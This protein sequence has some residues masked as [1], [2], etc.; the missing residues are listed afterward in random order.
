MSINFFQAK[1]NVSEKLMPDQC[2]PPK[3]NELYL[4]IFGGLKCASYL[5]LLSNREVDQ[6]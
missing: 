5:I 6:E 3:V 2:I 4:L 1:Y